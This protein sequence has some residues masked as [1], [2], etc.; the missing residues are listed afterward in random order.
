MLAERPRDTPRTRRAATPRVPLGPARAK[1][2]RTRRTGAAVALVLLLLGGWIQTAGAAGGKSVSSHASQAAYTCPMHPDVRTAA[3]GVC[4]RCGMALTPA[5]P[6]D[7]REYQVELVTAP[8]PPVSRRPLRV[9]LLVRN[10]QTGET[11]REFAIVHEQPFHLFVISQDLE[12]YAHVHPTQQPDGSFTIDLI[13]PQPGPYK[14]YAEFLPL[15]GTPQ[16]IPRSLVTADFAGDLAASAASLEPDPVTVAGSRRTLRK[17]VD[18]MAVELELP[19]E[20]LVAGR[21]EKF[22]YRLVDATTGAPIVD[23]EPYLGAWGH[24]LIVS[25]DTLSLVH[26]HPLEFLPEDDRSARGGPTLTF[27][28]LLPKPGRY[29]IWTQVK[30]KGD[31]STVTFTVAVGSPATM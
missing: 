3:P 11:V 21:E 20:G 30:R 6:V 29:R 15:G 14:V 5:D 10:G 2:S 22:A 16:V 12:H 9:R 27:K 8:H 7:T 24:S 1:G 23:L 13:L 19:P 28:A 25:E 31:V 26:A 18:G 4:P 17:T